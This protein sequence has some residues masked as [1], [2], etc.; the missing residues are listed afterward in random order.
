[1]QSLS[2]DLDPVAGVATALVG[3]CC[4]TAEG[5]KQSRKEVRRALR[6]VGPDGRV[7]VAGCAARLHP[8]V[9]TQMG[10][11]VQVLKS[12]TG[13]QA[14]G[15]QTQSGNIRLQTDSLGTHDVA[16]RDPESPDMAH[17]S[18]ERTRFFLKVQD[19]CANMCS[20]C[21]IPQVRG[22]PR[23]ISLHEILKIARKAIASGYAELVVTGINTGSYIDADKDIADLMMELSALDGLARLRLSSV[24]AVHISG[25]LLKA[26]SSHDVIGRHLHLPLQSGDDG[27]LK[28]MGRRYDT[29][30]FAAVL[31]Q[32]REAI[33]EINLTTDVITGFPAEDAR[34]FENTADFIQRTGFSKVHVFPYSPRPGTKA[35]K[36]G[37]PVSVQEKRR[38]SSRLRELSEQLQ[39]DH[40]QRKLGHV[41]EILL[42]SMR[43]P[44]V[45][46]GYSSDYTRYIVEGG[47]PGSMAKVSGGLVTPEGIWG[48]V[49]RE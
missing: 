41:D 6:R 47:Q 13:T 28:A 48:K 21:V 2:Q 8:D 23:S 24:E 25:P 19:G 46:A 4:V 26:M 44:G 20:Y 40:R 27:V 3:T 22:R 15:T 32:I 16:R 12:G 34:A 45:H 30:S 18:D 11:N 14:G 38:R 42:E 5:E 33:P 10:K 17:V 9:F 49:M 29:Q 35:A 1:M 37:D 43:G 36:L 39:D 31:E 7:F